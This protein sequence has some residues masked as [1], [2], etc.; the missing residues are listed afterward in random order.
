MPKYSYIATQKYTH[1]R[2]M[3]DEE[4]EDILGGGEGEILK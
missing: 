4:K 1:V 3:L 2:L